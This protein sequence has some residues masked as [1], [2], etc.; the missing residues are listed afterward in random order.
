M[1]S[2]AALW[3]EIVSRHGHLLQRHRFERDEV[4][5]GRG[6]DND[7]I[8]DDP[9]VA[10]R[11]VRIVRGADNALLAEEVESAN[12]L[13]EGDGK[14]RVARIALNDH[15]SIRIGRTYLR[16][17]D[18]A[19]AVAPE[20]LV[21]ARIW[22]WPLMVGLAIAMVGVQLASTW[23]HQ[24]T[25]PRMADYASAALTA[26]LAVAVWIAMWT[27][28]S[29]IFSGR[30]RFQRHLIIAVSGFLVLLVFYELAEVG[31]FALSQRGLTAYR[32]VGLWLVVGFFTLLHLRAISASHSRFK[33]GA[34]TAITVAAIGMQ[35]VAGLQA[36]ATTDLQSYVRR[37][38][39]PEFRLA[40]P[41]SEERF[42]AAAQGLKKTLDRWRTEQPGE[43]GDYAVD[44]DD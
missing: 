21:K 44:D 31:A 36:R 11:H 5:I 2:S 28:L 20:R 9:F 30:A 7:L 38:K 42:F 15:N 22:A 37:L 3:I 16:V 23:L 14:Q 10:P 41:Q 13:Y 24:T 18:A 8:L 4:R 17:R 6:Y 25:E 39:P 32:Y 35:T 40:G 43:I 12:G 29:R 19:H 27:I 33:A 34:V 1:P 26:C